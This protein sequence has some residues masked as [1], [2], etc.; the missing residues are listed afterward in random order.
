M[1]STRI[2]DASTMMPKS[3]APTE[4]RLADSPISTRIMMLKNRA[5]G[6]LMPTMTALRRSPRKTHWMKNTSRK[7]K[8]SAC[9]TVCVVVVTSSERS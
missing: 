7:P 3:T 2:T 5:N 9:S 1:F 8:T 6:M 4:S